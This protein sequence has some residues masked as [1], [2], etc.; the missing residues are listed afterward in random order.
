MKRLKKNFG[1][2]QTNAS[3]DKRQLKVKKGQHGGY[4]EAPVTIT[5]GF[6]VPDML[7]VTKIPH[8]VTP[9]LSIP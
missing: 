7:V 9:K 6:R 3:A 2:C 8:K 1:Y 4:L 5:T